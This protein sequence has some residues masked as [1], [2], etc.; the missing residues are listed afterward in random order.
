MNNYAV[1]LRHDRGIFTLHLNA[2]TI[3][4][5]LETALKTERAPLSAVIKIEREGA[6]A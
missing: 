1:T 2:A 4:A 3:S 6:N 5:A